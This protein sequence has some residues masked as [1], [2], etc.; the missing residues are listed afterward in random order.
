MIIYTNF[1]TPR[2]EDNI[3]YAIWY[4]ILL[5]HPHYTIYLHGLCWIVQANRK[6]SQLK[7]AQKNKKNI[8]FLD[9][10]VIHFYPNAMHLMASK[11]T[12]AFI[13]KSGN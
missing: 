2:Q 10:H 5:D 13:I 4:T 7:K 1:G 6:I 3:L 9:G 11:H 8:I 12:Q